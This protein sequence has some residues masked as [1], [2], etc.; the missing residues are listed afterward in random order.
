[1]GVLDIERDIN[2]LRGFSSDRLGSV[3][4]SWCEGEIIIWDSRE[5][6]TSLM[7]GSSSNSSVTASLESSMFCVTVSFM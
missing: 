4:N 1:M 2:Y 7:M 3:T 6:L 5:A